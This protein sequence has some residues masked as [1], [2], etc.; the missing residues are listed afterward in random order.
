M[1]GVLGGGGTTTTTLAP[2]TTTE[3]PTTTTTTEAPPEPLTSFVGRLVSSYTYT[4]SGR[5]ATA[6]IDITDNGTSADAYQE[7][8]T[9]DAAGNLTGDGTHT[10]VYSSNRLTQTKVGTETVREFTFDSGMRWR[11]GEGPS[12]NPDEETYSYTGTGRLSTY[13]EES[14]GIQATYAYDSVGQR[15]TSTVTAGTG[16]DQEVTT[17]SYTY[18]GL[19]LHKL[20][21]TRT[22]GETLESW[23][24][25]YLYDEYGKPYAGVYRSPQTSTTPTVFALLT[26]DRGDVV[27]LLD[28]NGAP[29]AAYR[30]D[31]WGN[32]LGE[33][34]ISEGIWAE[35]TA[36]GATE[37]LSLETATTIAQRQV[38]RYAG[39]CY[40]SESG[41][42]YLS[43]RHYDPETRQFLSKD[44]SRN[45][46]EQSAYGYCLGNPI[47]GTD[48]TGYRPLF[49][50]GSRETDRE[51]LKR[52]NQK[53]REKAKKKALNTKLPT[54]GSEWEFDPALWGQDGYSANC[55][56]YAV[57]KMLRRNVYD[58]WSARAVP[59]PNMMVVPGCLAKGN[60]VEVPPFAYDRNTIVQLVQAD[61][62]VIGGSIT[63][64]GADTV[65]QLG[66]RKI[67]LVI[68][69]N[70]HRK[71]FHFYEQNTNGA[72]SG[73]PGMGLPPRQLDGSGQ[74]MY[75][76]RASDRR[77]DFGDG[78]VFEY[79]SFEGY[80]LVGGTCPAGRQGL[81]SIVAR[82]FKWVDQ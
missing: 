44:L 20:Q 13:A 5:L 14:A 68:G 4:D 33:G 70:G 11:T 79:Q 18:T 34:N 78:V 63:E 37:V 25:T 50:T 55:Y 26:T 65:P 76:P 51:A 9:F 12:T 62:S 23:S 59:P 57:L 6:S 75:N 69:D 66:T 61:L 45:D 54:G 28:K 32:P 39:Y 36:Q 41:M 71:D 8:Y 31:A 16:E 46:G 82:S 38:L 80:F 15:Q 47:F 35:A 48:P 2:T 77:Y 60:G 3:P 24:I 17:T 29:F 42:Y 10:Y 56:L 64:C 49:E 52:W 43:A 58:D 7:S 67:A 40:D 53:N 1:G 22:Q 19:T 73:K 30:Y 72:F 21:A 74:V 27:A 81:P